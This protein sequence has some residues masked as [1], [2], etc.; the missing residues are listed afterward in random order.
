MRPLRARRGITNH[1]LW[2]DGDLR[3]IIFAFLDLTD[4][5]LRGDLSH[6]QQRLPDRRQ[7]RIRESR[8]GNIIESHDRHILRHA[9][10]R[11]AKRPYRPNRRNI[12]IRKER[13]ER[14]PPREQLLRYWEPHFRSGNSALDPY[15]EFRSNSNSQL[16]RHLA[17]R[18]PTL[19]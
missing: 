18:I 15:R 16:H 13:C 3:K 9:Q 10:S 5:R 12:V 7:S 11:L 8:S 6:P 4:Q 19:L 17:N 2:L 14:L 1:E